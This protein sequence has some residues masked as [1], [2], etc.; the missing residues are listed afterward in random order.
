MVRDSDAAMREFAG[1]VGGD[2]AREETLARLAEVARRHRALAQ[3]VAPE[4]ADRLWA[5][6]PFRPKWH[7]RLPEMLRMHAVHARHHGMLVR[8]TLES[9][10]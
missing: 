6:N 7:H 8:E 5:P 2:A 4:A 1:A 10:T 3:H 9:G